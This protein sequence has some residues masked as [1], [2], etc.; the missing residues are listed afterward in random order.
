M[1]NRFQAL[2]DFLPG[3]LTPEQHYRNLT[4]I[5]A[6]LLIVIGFVAG[7]S[8]VFS[9]LCAVISGFAALLTYDWLTSQ[10]SGDGSL[11]QASERIRSGA[12][13]FLFNL[14]KNIIW[15]S[16]C[17][18]LLI[19][20][21]INWATAIGFVI[22]VLLS[23]LVGYLGFNLTLST[24]SV[25]LSATGHSLLT[26][27][28]LALSSGVMSG[29]LVAGTALFALA[30]YYTLLIASQTDSIFA[31]LAGLASGAAS[32]AFLVSVSAAI[33][34]QSSIAA[35]RNNTSDNSVNSLSS[36]PVDMIQAIAEYISD[37][38]AV[39]TDLFATI[40]A[41]L[42]AT[43]I[44]N[45]V[46]VSIDQLVAYPMV[47]MAVAIISVMVVLQV[48]QRLKADIK[49]ELLLRRL[50]IVSAMLNAILLLPITWWMFDQTQLSEQAG[51]SNMALYQSVLIGLFLS[52]TLSAVTS[53]QHKA[54]QS[55]IN[56]L[57]PSKY[58]VAIVYAMIVIGLY[59]AYQV[60]G[61]IG[62]ELAIIS[63]LSL[64]AMMVAISTFSRLIDARHSQAFD[65]N[66]VAQQQQLGSIAK[67]VS[68]TYTLAA[69]VMVALILV[70]ASS[71]LVSDHAGVSFFNIQ[72]LVGIVIGVMMTFWF[73][74]LLIKAVSR[75]AGSSQTLSASHHAIS[76]LTKRCQ[77]QLL[78]PVLIPMI[79]SILIAL[80]FSDKLVNGLTIGVGVS[81]LLIGLA[82]LIGGE[83][84]LFVKRYFEYFWSAANP[85]TGWDQSAAEQ[86][87]SDH[88]RNAIV[89][90]LSPLIKIIAI[91][92]LLLT[93]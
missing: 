37:C 29:L 24:R 68:Q 38:T 18:A 36:Q 50:L 84:W 78:L 31:V 44:F 76:T 49:P 28:Q 46:Y 57:K 51:L 2:V 81:G 13:L 72:C 1:I 77:R 54:I 4:I 91:I 61:L 88:Y 14:Y 33:F 89:S 40:V 5:G 90:T 42:A 8:I 52:V 34:T 21:T 15:V 26:A 85:P 27:T 39:I 75:V 7:W 3:D 35:G 30:L 73:C 56:T 67:A 82:A 86:S 23:E 62:I 71:I 58:S 69:S 19:G 45:R 80:T 55:A 59:L 9:I 16:V 66:Q 6:A 41:A 12:Q 70:L 83:G 11:R 60:A 93:V 17:F 10:S 87:M 48:L 79:I 64:S 20:L 65:T 22:G 53:Y 32:V 43:L 74:A 25:S 47:I 92:S 63:L